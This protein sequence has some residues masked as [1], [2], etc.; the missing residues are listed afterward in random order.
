MRTNK[1]HTAKV[2]AIKGLSALTVKAVKTLMGGV[3]STPYIAFDIYDSF[4]V[5]NTL[6]V[7]R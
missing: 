6:E 4:E 1:A 5:Y 2:V 3:L 7:Y